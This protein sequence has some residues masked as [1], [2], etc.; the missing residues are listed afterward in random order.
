MVSNENEPTLIF[1]DIVISD[2]FKWEE[3]ERERYEERKH[4]SAEYIVYTRRIL[5]VPSSTYYI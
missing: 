2:Q 4:W 1:S 3:R 5:N